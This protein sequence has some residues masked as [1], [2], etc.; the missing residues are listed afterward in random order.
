MA[1]EFKNVAQETSR[2]DVRPRTAWLGYVIDGLFRADV[3]GDTTKY[4]VRYDDGSY[5]EVLHKGRVSLPAA[6]DTPESQWIAVSVGYDDEGDYSILSL[7][8]NQALGVVQ[9]FGGGMQLGAHGHGINDMNWIS[10]KTLSAGRLL[11]TQG[12]QAAFRT[13]DSLD[14]EEM[15]DEVVTYLL[16]SIAGVLKKMKLGSVLGFDANTIVTDANG[17]VVVD[18]LGNV[19]TE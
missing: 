12:S 2:A 4:I 6:F 5:R 17:D 18:A 19:V 9:R 3:E 15:P 10:D 14:E 7:D 1:G 8:R 11:I 13:I 16:I